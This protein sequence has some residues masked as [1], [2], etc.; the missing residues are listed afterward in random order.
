MFLNK[1]EK[2]LLKKYSLLAEEILA[3]YNIKSKARYTVT[4][5][6]S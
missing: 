4:R 6:N 5:L 1:V 3:S 2:K